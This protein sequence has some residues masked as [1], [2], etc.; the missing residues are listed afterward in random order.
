MNGVHPGAESQERAARSGG[1]SGEAILEMVDR[2][3]AD[4][5]GPGLVVV[6]VGCGQGDLFKVLGPRCRRYVGVDAVR[7][8]GLPDGVEFI[9]ADLDG[10][11]IAD[12]LEGIGDVVAAV[13]TIE[14]LE[15]PRAFVRL[16][17]RLARPGGWV[18]VTTPNQRSLLSLAS[19][20]VKG[21]FAHFQDVHYPA[22]L[23]ALLE[24]DLRRIAGEAGLEEVVIEYSGSGR[25]PLTPAHYPAVLTR[26]FPRALSDNLMVVGRRPLR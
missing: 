8:P 1:R 14:H 7:Y 13:E 3:V 11:A 24:V 4:R 20:V 2:A 18:L 26:L 22:H 16:L 17:A 5:V 15:N 25:L 9:A 23:T 19:L 21:Q 12:G 10:G 6:D